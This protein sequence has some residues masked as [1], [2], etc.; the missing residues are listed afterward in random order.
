MWTHLRSGK[1]REVFDLGKHLLLVATDRISAFDC[2]LPNAIPAETIKA[3]GKNPQTSITQPTRLKQLNSFCKLVPVLINNDM[4]KVMVMRINDTDIRNIAGYNGHI[5]KDNNNDKQ[6]RSEDPLKPQGVLPIILDVDSENEEFE[7]PMEL[8]EQISISRYLIT[9]RKMPPYAHKVARHSLYVP[10]HQKLSFKRRD[11]FRNCHNTSSQFSGGTRRDK[12]RRSSMVRAEP[13]KRMA[14]V[15]KKII[16]CVD[17]CSQDFILIVDDNMSNRFVLKELLKKRGYNSIEA[18]DGAD[19]VNIIDKHIKSGTI[20]R[21]L[22]VFMDLQM[23]IMD[24]IE[25]TKQI[26]SL[27]S[28]AG[29][30]TPHIIGVSSDPSEDDRFKFEQAGIDEFVSKPLDKEKVLSAITTHIQRP[31]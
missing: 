9:P 17:D 10:A 3:T 19:A 11:S 15:S 23:P 26:I 25:S 6:F 2:I 28:A 13:I 27:C 7:V 21:L 16:R 22:L 5:E 8:Q 14:D 30:Y 12:V 29:A 20:R 31:V 4:E 18:L 1:V 24:G